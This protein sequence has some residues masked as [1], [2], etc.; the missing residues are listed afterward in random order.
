[1]ATTAETGRGA[2]R[3]ALLFEDAAALIQRDYCRELTVDSVARAIYTSRRQVQRA[4]AEAGT[5][6]RDYVHSV[7]M[8]RA[9]DLLRSTPLSVREIGQRVGYRQPAQFAK[10]FRRSS[11]S[12]PS[13]WREHPRPNAGEVPVVGPWRGR[14][15]A[16]AHPA[17]RAA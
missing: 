12:T 15:S 11:G 16:D 4:F 13:A 8:E 7:R 14:P 5:T 17:D 9:A 2:D 6:V 10:A 3:R 1:M